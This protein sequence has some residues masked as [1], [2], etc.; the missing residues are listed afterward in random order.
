MMARNYYRSIFDELDY[1]RTYMDSLVRQ[2]SDPRRIT[3]LPAAGEQA[4]M[5]P[6]AKSNLKV[7]VTDHNG[8][9]V[10]T[11]DII[12]GVGKK[13]ISID[14][15]NPQALEISCERREEKK[16]EKEGYYMRERSF[17]SMTRVIPLPEPVTDDG[18]KAVFKNGIVEIHLKKMNKEAGSKIAIE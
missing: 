11:A 8:E 4:K 16:E 1:L 10:V 9:I 6:A 13:D 2:V 7:D 12:A 5:L 3:L 17:G 18:A 15:I 14:L